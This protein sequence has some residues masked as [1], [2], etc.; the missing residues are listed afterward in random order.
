VAVLTIYQSMKDLWFI[1]G[2]GADESVFSKLHF[3]GWHH[4]FISWI[5]PLPKESLPAYARRLSAQ[6]TTPNP[7]LIGYSFGGMLAVEMAHFLPVQRVIVLASS[8]TSA[9]IPPY[10]RGYARLLPLLRLLHPQW[11]ALRLPWLIYRLFGAKDKQSKQVLR[12]FIKEA[13]E[14]FLIWAMQAIAQWKSRG[15]P[16]GVRH[17]HGTADKVLP[18]RYVKAD[19]AIPHGGHLMVMEQPETV[20]RALSSLLPPSEPTE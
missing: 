14:D 13:D 11:I 9:E 6:I 7:V 18:F 3:D 17:I 5:P 1:S 10:Y 8:K 20:G 15:I 12:S 2:L 19:V 4:H 16:D